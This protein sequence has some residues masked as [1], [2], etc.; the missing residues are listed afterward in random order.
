MSVWGT[1]LIES[2]LLKMVLLHILVRMY[3]SDYSF[4]NLKDSQIKSFRS[5]R[6]SLIHISTKL[7][8]A[9]VLSVHRYVLTSMALTHASAKY[10]VARE[11]KDVVCA[12]DSLINCLGQI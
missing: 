10:T 11:A 8:H 1:N 12:S 5:P 4:L 2:H 3:T 6:Q 9:Q 7:S